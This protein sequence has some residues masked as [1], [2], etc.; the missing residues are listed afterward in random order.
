MGAWIDLDLGV[1][2]LHRCRDLVDDF[3]RRV[4]IGFGAA[5]IKLGLGLARGQMRA[6]GLVGGQMRAV[7]RCGG[8][9]AIRKMRRRV[10][11]I[12][13]AHAVADGADNP[14]I[15]GRL[16]VGIGE[17]GGGVLHHQGNVDRVHVAEHPLALG[18]F[19]VRRDRPKFHDAG[20][21]IQVRQHHVVAGG[22]EPARHVAQFFPDCR[23]VHVKDDD[24]KGSAAFG[25]ADEGGGVAVLGGDFDLL[26]DHG[27]LLLAARF[28]GLFALA[29]DT[30]ARKPEHDKATGRLK[31]QQRP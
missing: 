12:A 25:M 28:L 14:G 26:V 5:E 9:D 3:L 31:G 18:R 21:V 23:R 6:V 29:I 27:A 30:I 19:R 4:D 17:Q 16:L 1:G 15:R 7:D 20:A 11:R 13:S 8:L 24:G 2:A 22:G 10:D